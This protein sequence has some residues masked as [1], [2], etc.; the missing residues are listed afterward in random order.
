MQLEKTDRPRKRMTELMMKQSVPAYAA[1]TDVDKNTKEFHIVFQRSPQEISVQDGVATGVTLQK[2]KL[3]GDWRTAKAVPTGETETIDCQL[4]LRSI[5]YKSLPIKGLPFDIV[6]GVV[7]NVGGYVADADDSATSEGSQGGDKLARL[8]AAGWVKTGP[9]G[10]ILSTMN[11]A[12]ETADVIIEDFN[13]GRLTGKDLPKADSTI[14]ELLGEKKVVS[15]DDWK[16][17][18]AEEIHRG[19]LLSKPFE[20]FTSTAEMLQWA[21]AIASNSDTPT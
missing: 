14:D 12:F 2:M 8:Y 20:K 4:I 7:P 15:F 9:V 1:G 10:V 5:G 11:A 21:T 17:I 16:R 19:Q 18:E 3:E 6:R 13:S